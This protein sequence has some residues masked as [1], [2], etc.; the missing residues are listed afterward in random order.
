MYIYDYSSHCARCC[1]N[2]RHSTPFRSQLLLFCIPNSTSALK[3]EI[4]Q[5]ELYATRAITPIS[6]IQYP[7]T[8]KLNNT[9]AT[10]NRN[11]K[12]ELKTIL[13]LVCWPTSQ[14]PNS[15]LEPL[16]SYEYYRKMWL[17]I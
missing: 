17:T 10:Q 8:D 12:A 2:S 6:N 1:S 14:P 7:I 13:V 3:T 16:P 9:L 4:M 15:K 11:Q 5:V